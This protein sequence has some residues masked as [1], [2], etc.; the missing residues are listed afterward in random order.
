MNMVIDALP[1]SV[2]VCGLNVP[3][4]T[5]FR[6]WLMLEQLL[7]DDELT[8]I[9]RVALALNLVYIDKSYQDTTEAVNALIWFY[10]GGNPEDKRLTK[11]A[12]KKPPKKI[13]DIDQDAEYIFAAF[14]QTYKIDLTVERLHWWKFRALLHGLPEE[15]LFSKI[16]G[17]RATNLGQIKDKE[18]RARI[19]QKQALYRIRTG[20]TEEEK[21]A[22]LYDSRV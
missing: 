2:R 9:E 20:K 11:I 17:Y 12:E 21:I 1:E 8:Q 10:R 13:Y 5:D 14:W 22:R 19:G 15:C 16:M 7:A 18:T 6:V 3:I 4:R